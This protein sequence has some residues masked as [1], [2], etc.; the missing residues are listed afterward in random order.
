MTDKKD[1]KVLIDVLRQENY[2]VTFFSYSGKDRLILTLDEF[3]IFI[4]ELLKD[5]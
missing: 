4:K 5:D 1:I 2:Y 3:K